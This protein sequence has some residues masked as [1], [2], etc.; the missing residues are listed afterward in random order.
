MKQ[1]YRSNFI[2]TLVSVFVLGSI[3]SCDKFLDEMPSKTTSL[4]VTTTA[5]LDALLNNYSSFYSEGN[6]TAIYSTD[7]Y[8]LTK[9]LYD[10]RPGTFSSMATIEFMLW[11]IPFLPDDTREGFW[12]GE[13]RKIFNANMAL[14]YVDKV[15]GPDADKA[16]IRADAYLIRAYSYWSLANT[17]CLPYTE[18]NKNEVG[19]PI[20]TGTSFEQPFE[21]RPLHEVYT[22]IE[23]DIKEALKINVTLTQSG[24]ARHW[25]ASKAGVNG[26]AARYYLSRFNYP[27]ALE[28]ATA[29]LEEYST[30]VDYNVNMTYGNDQSVTINS[31]TPQQQTVVLKYPYTHNNQIDFT[32]MLGWKEFLYFRMLNHES[33]WYIPSQGLLNLY[34]KDHDLRYK[35]HMVEGYSYD[36]GMTKPSY[37]Y[38]G[39]IFFFKD[40]IPSGPTVAEMHLIKAEAHARMNNITEAMNSLNTLRAK[41]MMPGAWV[42]LTA[43]SKDDAIKKVIDERRR[44]MPFVQRWYDLRRYNNNED[45]NDDVEITKT[46]YPYTISAVLTTQ[47]VKNYVLQKNSRRYAAPI[48]RTEL[49]S[50]DGVITQNTY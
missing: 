9:Q 47:P 32:D 3:S 26:F 2:K 1:T 25:R 15:T 22:M 49:I 14:E 33:W 45:P 39:Y 36:R 41:R 4:V 34:D 37:D 30:L 6:R 16:A 18:A 13:Y 8:E 19:L 28:H 17:Y 35:Y 10:A 31:G 7:D 27:K 50:S 21:R 44:E 29:A 48:P 42:N 12:S 5:Q 11:D 24:K 20:K 38:P 40:R 43:S 23:S 46:F